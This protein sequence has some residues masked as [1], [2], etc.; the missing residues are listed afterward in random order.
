MLRGDLFAH[1][2][3]RQICYTGVPPKS[4]RI[5]CQEPNDKAKDGKAEQKK[6]KKGKKVEASSPNAMARGQILKIGV[7]TNGFQF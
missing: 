4:E 6:G 1:A 7:W 2:Y 5:N 3:I